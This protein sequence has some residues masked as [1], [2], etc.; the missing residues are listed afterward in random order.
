M[1][2]LRRHWQ[3]RILFASPTSAQRTYDRPP[4]EAGTNLSTPLEG[5]QLA[6]G[7]L[8]RRMTFLG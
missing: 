5:S 4:A 8:L 1:W 6:E 7:R 2:C 3:P